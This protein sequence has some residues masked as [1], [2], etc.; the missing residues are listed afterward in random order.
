MIDD[1][2]KDINS[3]SYTLYIKDK[4][5]CKEAINVLGIDEIS[6]SGG[7]I[8]TVMLYQKIEEHTILQRKFEQV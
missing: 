4:Q 6:K 5:G 7:K 1:V 2:L 8:E 3:E